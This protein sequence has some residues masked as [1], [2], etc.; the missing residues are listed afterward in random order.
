[1]ADQPLKD[2]PFCG[3]DRVDVAR[4]NPNA[5]WIRCANDECGADAKSHRTRAGAFR[6]WNRRDGMGLTAS[7]RDDDDKDRW[8]AA[9]KRAKA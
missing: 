4:T 3:S 9:Q 7:I 5:C 2:C 1:M 8:T 6:N